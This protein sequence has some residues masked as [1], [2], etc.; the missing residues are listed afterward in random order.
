MDMK[1]TLS[2]LLLLLA[3]AVCVA[4]THFPKNFNV[5]LVGGIN[6]VGHYT[7]VA[8]IGYT[9]NSLCRRWRWARE[10]SLEQ[11]K[12]RAFSEGGQILITFKGAA[13]LSALRES[14]SV[15]F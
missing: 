11:I 10:K 2:I 3:S 8:S 14:N 5:D 12:K 4:Q 9:F 1:K 13:G 7:P 15:F 6:D